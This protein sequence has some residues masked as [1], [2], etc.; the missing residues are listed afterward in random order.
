MH[1]FRIYFIYLFYIMYQTLL[2]YKY[3][4]IEDA[5]EFAE[6]HLAFCKNLGLVGRILV[7]PEGL[8]GTVSGTPDKC[9]AYMQA[10][11]QDTRFTGIHWKID[12]VS[13]PSFAK[14]HVRLKDEIVHSG[15]V[16]L[17]PT[18]FEDN[19]L[20]PAEFLAMKAQDDVVVLDVRSNYEHQLG[21]FKN[22]VTLDMDN[23]RELPEHLD[24][25][26]QYKD[27]KILTYCTGGIKCE[28]ASAFLRQQGFKEVYQLS[29]GII[30]Y[31]KQVG[32]E[33]FEGNCYV[34]D[35]RVQV[36]VNTVNPTV[37][38]RCRNCG[39]TTARMVNCANPHCNDHFVQCSHC[40]ESLH[41]ACSIQCEKSPSIRTYN[42]KGYYAKEMPI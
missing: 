27:K 21:R 13:E 1:T 16:E 32:G 31:G 40:G 14:M 11:E 19:H 5:A 24:E 22:A 33:D 37:I 26:A 10:V 12:E 39:T 4:R 42:A 18:A 6:Q 35:N 17:D 9:A 7:A 29:G 15:L 36:P 2:Y 23:F 38:T 34:F 28:K 8:N 25:L 20:S 41:G 30:N 3:A